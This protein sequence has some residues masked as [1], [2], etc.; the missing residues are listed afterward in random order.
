MRLIL[1]LNS[2]CVCC[3][4]GL[5]PGDK[6]GIAVGI[7]AA[8][9]LAAALAFYLWRRKQKRRWMVHGGKFRDVSLTKA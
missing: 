6:A 8:V 9:A 5:T 2:S 7:I 3:S 1:V 4:T